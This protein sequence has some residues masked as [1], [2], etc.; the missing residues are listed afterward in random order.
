[1]SHKVKVKQ[2]KD[3]LITG[4]QKEYTFL[5]DNAPLEFKRPFIIWL[6]EYDSKV[7]YA[8]HGMEGKNILLAKSELNEIELRLDEIESLVELAHVLD[9]L[10]S[11]NIK[12]LAD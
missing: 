10:E 1:M 3:E 5:T 7:S 12:I 8:V 2:L 9:E 4:I 11:N 6:T